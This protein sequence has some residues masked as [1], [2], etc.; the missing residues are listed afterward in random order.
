MPL[1]IIGDTLIRIAS[2]PKRLFFSSAVA[3]IIAR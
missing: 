1:E 3:S 2:N